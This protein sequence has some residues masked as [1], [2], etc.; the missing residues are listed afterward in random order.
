MPSNDRITHYQENQ[1]ASLIKETGGLT[2][3]I[4]STE[5][6]LVTV[7]GDKKRITVGKMG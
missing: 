6:S 1:K 5:R 2:V 7:G 4:E 3:I